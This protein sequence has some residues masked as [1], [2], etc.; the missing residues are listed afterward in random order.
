M[1]NFV[2]QVFQLQIEVLV[3]H[4]A[5]QVVNAADEPF[6]N[7]G[8]HLVGGELLDVFRNFVAEILVGQWRTRHADHGEFPRQQVVFRQI[9]ERGN[10]LAAGQVAAGAKNHHGAGIAELADPLLLHCR[11]DFSLG[12]IYFLSVP[13]ST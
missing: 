4:V 12:H 2:E 9:V 7:A 3:A 10:Q 1:V 13:G 5:A 11:H 8:V 6:P